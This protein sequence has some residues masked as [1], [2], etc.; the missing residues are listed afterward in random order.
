MI[1]H[2]KVKE[3]NIKPE[4]V[5]EL[6]IQMETYQIDIKS[7]FNNNQTSKKRAG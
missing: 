5:R 6:I 1:N 7:I 3:L 2:K 4:R